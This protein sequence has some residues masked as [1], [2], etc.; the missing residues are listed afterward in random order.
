MTRGQLEMGLRFMDVFIKPK[1]QVTPG[2]IY[3]Q[4]IDLMRR[5][6]NHKRTY[7]FIS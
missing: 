6:I 7:V 3:S 5:Y 4:L 2:S 1:L